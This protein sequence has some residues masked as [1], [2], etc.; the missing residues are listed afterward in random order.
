MLLCLTRSSAESI[1]VTIFSI[2]KKAAR[3]AVYED[4]MINVKNHHALPIIR[5]ET[6]LVTKNTG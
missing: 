5:P 3:L 6:D 2:V 1:G 4:M